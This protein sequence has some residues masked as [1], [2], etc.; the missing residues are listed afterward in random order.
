MTIFGD[1][2]LLAIMGMKKPQT[3]G[4]PIEEPVL[5]PE[6][7]ED[8]PIVAEGQRLTKRNLLGKIADGILMAYGKNPI[9]EGRMRERDLQNAMDS[10]SHD[11]MGAIQRIGK[12]PGMADEAFGLMDKFQDNQRAA[13]AAETLAESRRAKF[14]PRIGG[15]LRNVLKAENRDEAYRVARPLLQR[16]QEKA[17]DTGSLPDVFDEQAISNYI[18][19]NIDPEDQLRQ[20]MLD[21][22]RQSRLNQGQQRIDETVRYHNERLEDFDQQ[23]TGRNN[24]AA[25]RRN[26]G[27]D[28]SPRPVDTRFGPGRMSADGTSLIVFRP[29]GEKWYYEIRNGQAIRV[30]TVAPKAEEE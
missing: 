4:A 8:I 18:A 23:E 30:N 22:Y 2:S 11:P 12:L 20:E 7:G 5:A 6:E 3:M 26:G 13:E 14:Y 28:G 16:L 27:S 21:E 29:G 15:L 25:Q 10:F 9:Y 19:M 24:R 1:D 17:G